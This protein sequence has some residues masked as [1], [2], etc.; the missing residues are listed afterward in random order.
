MIKRRDFIKFAGG[1]AVAGPLAA[2]AQQRS[3]VSPVESSQRKK[4]IAILWNFAS[5][6]AEGQLRLAFAQGLAQLGWTVGQKVQIDYRWGQTISIVSDETW[7][8]LSLLH[9]MSSLLRAEEI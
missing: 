5:D 9:P 6:D 4:R 1:A 8:I 3:Q 7:L 2:R